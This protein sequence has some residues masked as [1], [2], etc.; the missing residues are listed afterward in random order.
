VNHLEIRRGVAEILSII[1]GRPVAVEEI[2][3]RSSE[4]K[5]D[6]LRHVE[7]IL[8]MEERFNLSFTE[9]E[10]GAIDSSERICSLI[11]QRHGS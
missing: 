11:E 2:V 6:S 1:L 3:N 7:L 4:N 9:E 10:M 8:L 5:W